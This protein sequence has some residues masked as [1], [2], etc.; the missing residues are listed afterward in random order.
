MR[1]NGPP[2]LL[3]DVFEYQYGIPSAQNTPL[4]HDETFVGNRKGA[5]ERDEKREGGSGRDTLTQMGK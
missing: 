5:R 3:K 1:D 2:Y 4:S